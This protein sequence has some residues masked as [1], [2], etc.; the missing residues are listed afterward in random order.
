MKSPFLIVSIITTLAVSAA[1]QDVK[2]VSFELKTGKPE[3]R[4]VLSERSHAVRETPAANPSLGDKA[5]QLE[6]KLFGMLNDIRV[7]QGLTELVWNDDV[8][9]VA[10]LHS[11]NMAEQNFFSHRGSDGSMVDD[12]ADKVGLGNWRLIGENIA[13]VKGFDDPGPVAIEKWLEST[14]HRQNLL[15]PNWEFSAVGVAVT[16][17]GVY[18]ITQVFLFR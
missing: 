3:V 17:D 15:R 11:T 4:P 9:S 12:R 10:R 1:A 5:H 14:M 16:A 2:N 7:K 8:A 18:Y 13:Y 6:R